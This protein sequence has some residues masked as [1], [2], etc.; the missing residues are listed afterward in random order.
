MFV[1]ESYANAKGDFISVIKQMK[2]ETGEPSSKKELLRDIIEHPTDLK[3][4]KEANYQKVLKNREGERSQIFKG[5]S[6]AELK[7]MMGVV[8]RFN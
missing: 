4:H 8:S 7:Q 3:K 5:M 2:E 1:K 6:P